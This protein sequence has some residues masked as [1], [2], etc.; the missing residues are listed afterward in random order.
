PQEYYE[1]PQAIAA[2]PRQRD[3]A[4]AWWTRHYQE[5]VAKMPPEYAMFIP[6]AAGGCSATRLQSA[7]AF[8]ADPKNQKS[9]TMNMLAKVAEGTQDCL[10]LRE[11]EGA[12]VD[13]ALGATAEAGA[14]AK[15]G[16]GSAR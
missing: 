1:I 2:V 6:F 5:V 16:A 4:W 10:E 8:F 7:Q 11:R 13:R 15:G 14:G 9:G 12:A 3:E